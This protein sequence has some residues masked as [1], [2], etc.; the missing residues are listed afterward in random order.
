MAP[1]ELKELKTQPEDFERKGFIQPSISPWG[2]PVLFSEKKDKSLRLCTDYRELNK[3]T[4][5][6]KYPLP[7][8]DDLFKQLQGSQVSSKIDLQS[9]YYQVKVRSSDIPKTAISARYGHYEYLV[10]P[11]GL[12]NAPAAFMDLMNRIFKPYLDKFVVN[13]EEH[14]KHLRTVLQI[15]REHKLYAKLKKCDFW[16]DRVSYLGHTISSEGISVDPKK[17]KTVSDWERPTT[18]T[19]IRSFLGMAGYYRRFIMDFANIASSLT[20]LTRKGVK[21]EWSEECEKSFE[22]LKNRL[23]TAPI[24]TL[25]TPGEGFTLYCDASKIGL[26][27]VL[28]QNGKVVAYASHQLRTHEE[29]YP[30]HDLELAAVI[31]ALKT[32]RHYLYGVHSEIYTDHK[33][34]KYIFTQ[35]RTK[36]QATKMDYDVN[37]NYHLGKANKV[38]DA[39]SRKATCNMTIVLT[40]QAELLRDLERLEVEV[41]YNITEVSLQAI[42]IKPTLQD[43]ILQKQTIDTNLQNL[44]KGILE[45]KLAE[46]RIDQDGLIR[47][48]NRLCVP[49]DVT[50]R[51]KILQE[52]HSS[53]YT[54]HPGSTKMYKD[55]KSTYWW[56]NMKR[57]IAQFVTECDICQQ[58]K[59]EHQRPT[60]L[61][62][63]LLVPVWKWEEIGMDFIHGLPRTPSGNDSI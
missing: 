17:V 29:N 30:T 59:A 47:F 18:V 12:T 4:I 49:N 39:L 36:Y 34:L 35:K 43:E 50:L 7:R 31:F 42:Q 15:L 6:N 45:G 52:A 41:R 63:P 26:G 11:F 38:A 3:V 33:S 24:L 19:E 60:G 28:M 32:W 37:I 25:P 58:I 20:R 22:E 51:R 62:Q 53:P 9:G 40:E 8:I 21:F 56:N 57:E 1:A 55:I 10:M 5:K 14:A 54:I 48:Q 44:K 16:M 23:V 27:C 46:F 61:L 13:R 2:A